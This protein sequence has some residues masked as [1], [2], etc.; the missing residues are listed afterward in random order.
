MGK[1]WGGDPWISDDM[2]GSFLYS[3]KQIATTYI[4]QRDSRLP[5]GR[6]LT[7]SFLTLPN[8]GIFIRASIDNEKPTFIAIAK[9]QMP[10]VTVLSLY[11]G[12]LCRARAMPSD[13]Q[14]R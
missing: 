12:S 8:P 5:V 13:Q 4:E 1:T 7:I 6:I 2:H 3:K 14:S 11:R 9:T 10:I